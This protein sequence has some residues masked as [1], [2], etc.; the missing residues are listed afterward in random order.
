MAERVRTCA[1]WPYPH[2]EPTY[3][4]C[5]RGGTC[6]CVCT[7]SPGMH[8]RGMQCPCS[9]KTERT[10]DAIYTSDTDTNKL[11]V[12]DRH[13]SPPRKCRVHGPYTRRLQSDPLNR[14]RSINNSSLPCEQESKLTGTVTRPRGVV[15]QLRRGHNFLVAVRRAQVKLEVAISLPRSDSHSKDKPPCLE[16]W[17]PYRAII[18]FDGDGVQC[19]LAKKHVLAVGRR[20]VD[21][22]R[23]A[24][25]QGHRLHAKPEQHELCGRLSMDLRPTAPQYARKRCQPDAFARKKPFHL[26]DQLSP[27]GRVCWVSPRRQARESTRTRHARSWCPVPAPVNHGVYSFQLQ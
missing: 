10:L 4:P 7:H 6:P 8:A 18:R 2:I 1:M 20:P 24:N 19:V 14:K 13:R 22:L 17:P 15:I 26:T 27:M 9:W 16:D 21:D 11:T 23:R 12:L 3:C 5:Q 25:P